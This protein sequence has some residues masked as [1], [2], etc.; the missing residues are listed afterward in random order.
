M[1]KPKRGS[2]CFKANTYS[3]IRHYRAFQS[4]S[5]TRIMSLEQALLIYFIFPSFIEFSFYDSPQFHFKKA[6]ISSSLMLWFFSRRSK[7]SERNLLFRR[8]SQFSQID[9][10]WRKFNTCEG[11]NWFEKSFVMHVL[12][13]RLFFAFCWV[14]GIVES[15]ETWVLDGKR[16]TGHFSL[17]HKSST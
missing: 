4:R 11:A 13:A 17:S 16:L 2:N 15:D 9:F 1:K 3:E 10:Y 7:Y 14:W 8:I 5:C 6:D 12:M